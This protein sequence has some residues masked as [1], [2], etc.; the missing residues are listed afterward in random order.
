M[1]EPIISTLSLGLLWLLWVILDSTK[2]QSD[3][4]AIIATF[5]RPIVLLIALYFL[6]RII[7]WSWETPI[8]FSRQILAVAPLTSLPFFIYIRR[9]TCFTITIAA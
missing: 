3:T 7:R 5:G 6:V 8:P 4:A 1:A 9:E 2:D